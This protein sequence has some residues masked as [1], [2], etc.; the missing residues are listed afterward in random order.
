MGR[1]AARIRE[2]FAEARKCA[3]CVVF[4]DELDAVGT[5]GPGGLEGRGGWEEGPCR[6]GEEAGRWQRQ[7]GRGGAEKEGLVI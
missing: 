6:P 2:L 5:L 7:R 1:G 3:P 4:V